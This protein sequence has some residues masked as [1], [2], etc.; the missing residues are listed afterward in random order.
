MKKTN[1][2]KAPA[3]RK[4]APQSGQE[5]IWEGPVDLQRMPIGPGRSSGK[6]GIQL[7]AKNEYPYEA[8][9]ITEKAKG[10]NNM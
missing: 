4:Y 3:E 2:Y 7:L 1:E 8:G 6:D 10:S 5:T 9:P